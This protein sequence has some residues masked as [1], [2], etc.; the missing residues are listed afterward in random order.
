VQWVQQR[1]HYPNAE[2]QQAA[3]DEVA[4]TTNKAAY[5][6]AY[7]QG[8]NGI[9]SNKLAELWDDPI[10]EAAA[11]KAAQTT[12]SE[13]RLRGYGMGPAES[14]VTA[15]ATGKLEFIRDPKGKPIVP[16]LIFWDQVQRELRDVAPRGTRELNI[17][18]PER[19][20]RQKPQQERAKRK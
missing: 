1:F 20:D 13:A 9:W 2:A 17:N 16:S 14:P 4:R 15:G 11:Q 7:A 6:K 19:C 3:L 5:D 8:A 12:R 10:I 18:G